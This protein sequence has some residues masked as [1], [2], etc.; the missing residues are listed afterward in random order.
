MYEN[1][2]DIQPLLVKTHIDPL[3]Q[4]SVQKTISPFTGQAMLLRSAK[5]IRGGSM[6][7]DELFTSSIAE[8]SGAL[9]SALIPT[10]W[11][12]IPFTTAIINIKAQSIVLILND[13]K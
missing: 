10:F 11:E 7:F 9:P 13:F 2:T 5:D 3:S 12:N 6:P 4:Q 8:L 1:G